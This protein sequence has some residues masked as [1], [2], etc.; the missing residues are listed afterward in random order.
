[1]IALGLL[2]AFASDSWGESKRTPAKGNQQQTQPQEQKAAPDQRGTDQLPLIVQPLPTKKT[3]EIAEQEKREAKEKTDSDWW[4]WFLGVLTIV[5]LFGQLAVFIAQ[6][7]FLKGTLTATAN[8]ANAAQSQARVFAA[9]EGPIP[10]VVGL[11]IVQYPVIPGTNILGADGLTDHVDPGPIPANC[12]VLIAVE[13]KGRTVLR[14]IELCIEKFIGNVLPTTPIYT[15]IDPWH[16]VLEKGPLWIQASDQLANITPA[17]VGAAAAAY[18]NGAMWVYGYF[19]YS[20]LLDE[21]VEH[22]FLARW[23]L[24][25]GFVADNRPG[26]T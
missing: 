9:V 1:V 22:K 11:K 4:T 19:A 21:R 6:A 18:P 17:D 5:A 7:Y 23:D 12:R 26:Y 20:N 10:V 16:L 8:A 24:T 25:Q 13:N 2:A 15:H 14:L 3:T